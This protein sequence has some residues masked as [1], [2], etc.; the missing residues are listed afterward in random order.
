[1]KAT[2]LI[3]VALAGLSIVA[4]SGS[5]SSSPEI[6]AVTPSK[7]QIDSVSYLLGINFGS[8]IKGYNFG[9]LNYAEMVKG[10]KDFVNSEGTPYDEDFAE[11][12]KID[13]NTMGDVING[14]LEKRSQLV[15]LTN[16]EAQDKFLEANKNKA[17]V[18]VS[19][20]GLQYQI[21]EPGS[22]THPGPQDTVYV[23]YKG[24][25]L[26]GTVF[27]EVASDADPIA[28][29]LNQVIPGWTEGIQ[30]VG[31]G[32]K[33]KLFVP[34]DLGYGASGTQGIE[35]NSLLIFD[36]EVAE[37]RPYVIPELN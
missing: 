28:L 8:T 18:S 24:T 5:K 3:I 34:A 27:D 14:F 16:K 10:M 2:K 35:P 9:D 6:K 26:D 15:S 17:N 30:L 32:G 12:F 7:A 23:R 4:C 36:V 19:P 31:E 20:S 22:S 37:V 21:I 33:I 29:T 13:P 1:M 25:L 11:Q